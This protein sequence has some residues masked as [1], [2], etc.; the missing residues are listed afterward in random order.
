AGAVTEANENNNCLASAGTINVKVPDLKE[1]AVSD[2]PASRH[3]GQSF[4]VTDTVKNVGN[5]AAV[6]SK[7]RYYLSTNK[8]L[9]AA[10]I[11][12]TGTRNV[13]ALNAG[14]TDPGSKSVT[15]PNATANGN[16]YVLACSDDTALV[17]ENSETNNCLA[18][19]TKVTIS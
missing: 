4:T 6:A 1:T 16:Y 19:A 12:L 7:T 3:A 9:S 11:L 5:L 14:A 8:T 18:S 15:I 2:P 17:S 10:D 13:G